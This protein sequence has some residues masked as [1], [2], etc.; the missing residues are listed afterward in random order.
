MVPAAVVTIEVQPPAL[1]LAADL[2]GAGAGIERELECA[3]TKTAIDTRGRLQ[4]R[5]VS[6]PSSDICRRPS[7]CSS[8]PSSVAI[9]WLTVNPIFSPR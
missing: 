3:Q 7:S 8:K 9:V 4:R 5:D 2:R 1:E 6:R